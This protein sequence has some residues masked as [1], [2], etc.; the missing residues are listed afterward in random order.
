MDYGRKKM[1][2]GGL[3]PEDKKRMGMVYGGRKTMKHGGAHNNMDRIK[4]N[5]GGAMETAKSV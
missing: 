5:M 2:H 4:M 3:H 1:K